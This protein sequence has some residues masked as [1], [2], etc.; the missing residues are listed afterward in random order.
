[1]KSIFA[2]AAAATLFAT[3]GMAN[4][5][6]NGDFENGT[7]IANAG[8]G[9][10][11]LNVGSTAMTGWTVIG[12]HP[13][14]WLPTGA[15]G[16]TSQSGK[17]LLDLTGY[18]DTKPYGG[19]SQTV[20]LAVGN[21]ILTF[22]LGEDQNVKVYSGPV[23]ASVS[24]GSSSAVFTT[25][26]PAGAT[27][28]IWQQQTFNFSVTSAGPITITIIGNSTAGWQAIGLDNVDLEPA[29]ATISSGGVVSAS[30]FGGFP[31]VAPGSW[32]EIHGSSLAS[33]SRGWTNADFSGSSA[34]TSLDGTSV[35]IAGQAA[36]ID[37]I[38]PTQINA[39]VP[40]GVPTGQQPVIV[41]APSG[42]SAP[43]TV[44][45][46]P[47]QPGLFAPPS[48]MMGGNQY[49]AALSSDGVTPIF[50]PGDIASS[51]S[52][53]AR[54]G[55]T[56][57]FYGTGFGPVTP[58]SPAGQIVQQA[59]ALVAPLQIFFGGMSANI[60]GAGLVQGSIGWYQFSVV[61]PSVGAS[62]AV[63]LTL[64]LGG[65]SG[66]QTLYIAIGN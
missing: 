64:T 18:S 33:D 65:V 7:F 12:G 46:N 16:V 6:T 61:V 60:V 20:N 21:Y 36:F 40:S 38:S 15:F 50:T 57:V 47:T 53:R 51:F 58:D 56:I 1:M 23:S 13:I 9:G 30:S 24:A 25:T 26:V 8:Q 55:D 2:I 59:N 44:T 5:L 4:L 42:T 45:V 32:I 14:A 22:Y 62:D 29:G 52:Q 34:P 43:Y 63:P 48:L 41:T 17:Y 19:V 54:P 27:G 66:T 39:Q 35:A 31:S 37:Y 11:S 10:D 49:V 28:V 3:G